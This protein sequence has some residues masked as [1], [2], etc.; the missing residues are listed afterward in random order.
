MRKITR[1]SFLAA[2][3]ACDNSTYMGA[4]STVVICV[5]LPINEI[6]EGYYAV[7]EIYMRIYS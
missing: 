2:A 1:R 5:F 7:F 6:F 3:A 4:V